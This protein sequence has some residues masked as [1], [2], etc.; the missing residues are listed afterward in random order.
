[1][2]DLTK[3]TPEEAN[4]LEMALIQLTGNIE[5]KIKAYESI[6]EDEEFTIE[7]RN[8]MKSNAEWWREVLHLIERR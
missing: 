4:K 6:S 2:I 3:I 8:T 1:M 5:E 7:T